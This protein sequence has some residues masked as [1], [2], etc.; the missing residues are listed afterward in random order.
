MKEAEFRR[1]LENNGITDKAVASRLA[2]GRRAE[3]TLGY[4]LDTAVSTDDMMYDSL[5]KLQPHEDPLHNPM[6]NALR[7]YY[8][9]VQGKEFPQ[10]RYYKR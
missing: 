1:F 6:Q 2:R 5:R 3:E 7:K 9:F 8:I 10:L 4:S